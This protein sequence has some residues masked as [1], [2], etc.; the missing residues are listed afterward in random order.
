MASANDIKT[1]GCWRIANENPVNNVTDGVLL[2]ISPFR[3]TDIRFQ[4]LI[5]Y[6]GSVTYTRM[7]WYSKWY[8]WKTIT[9]K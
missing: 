4:F 6:D 2:N 1:N 9:L 3:N 8:S 5:N 7:Y